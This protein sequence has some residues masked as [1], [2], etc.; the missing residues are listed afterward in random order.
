MFI[1]PSPIVKK[2]N[3]IFPGPSACKIIHKLKNDEVTK[4]GLEDLATVKI[5]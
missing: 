2:R 3:N 4:E 5:T 1:F